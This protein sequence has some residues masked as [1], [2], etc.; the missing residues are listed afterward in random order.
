MNEAEVRFAPGCLENEY[1]L[2]APSKF[3]R[4]ELGEA[5]CDKTRHGIAMGALSRSVYLLEANSYPETTLR[6]P[7]M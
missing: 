5:R 1:G 6:P 4:F 7:M 2:T 3:G